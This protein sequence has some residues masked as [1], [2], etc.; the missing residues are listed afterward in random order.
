MHWKSFR[1]T[2]PKGK[3]WKTIEKCILSWLHGVVTDLFFPFLLVVVVLL[4][5]LDIF[6][7]KTPALVVNNTKHAGNTDPRDL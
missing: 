3:E 5:L 7:L 4:L 1:F 6:S 2:P